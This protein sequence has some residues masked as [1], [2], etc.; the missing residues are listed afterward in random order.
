MIE[1]DLWILFGMLISGLLAF[2]VAWFVT[3]EK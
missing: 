3:K 1:F 2:G